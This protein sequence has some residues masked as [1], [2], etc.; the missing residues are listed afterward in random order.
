MDPQQPLSA[1]PHFVS[2]AAGRGTAPDTPAPDAS[3][4]DAEEANA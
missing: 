1:A 2:A 3:V 4:I